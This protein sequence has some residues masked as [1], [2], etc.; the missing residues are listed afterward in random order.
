MAQGHAAT[1]TPE[2]AHPARSVDSVLVRMVA[3]HCNFVRYIMDG[4]NAVEKS[5][6]YEDQQTKGKVVQKRVEIQVARDE[7]K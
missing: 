4:Y 5:D 6:Q 3:V 7:E 1:K 2:K